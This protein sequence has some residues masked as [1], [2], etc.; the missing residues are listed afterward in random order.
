[1]D[2]PLSKSEMQAITSFIEH[3]NENI[4]A[5]KENRFIIEF[6]YAH[7]Y[8]IP[9]AYTKGLKASFLVEGADGFILAGEKDMVIAEIKSCNEKAKANTKREW[10]IGI[11]SAIIGGIFA[12]IG[13]LISSYLR[14]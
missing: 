13:S 4:S 2:Y 11:S 9:G 14:R 6:L 1:M 12:V 8:L 5:S 3:C 10:K 7:R